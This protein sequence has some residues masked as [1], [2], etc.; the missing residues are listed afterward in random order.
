MKKK[1]LILKLAVLSWLLILGFGSFVGAVD[2]IVV[3]AWNIEDLGASNKRDST[4]KGVLQNATDIAKYVKDS[5]V[6][7]LGLE[8]ICVDKKESPGLTNSSLDE[9]V[10]IL[11]ADSGANWK[12][13]LFMA[14]GRKAR[15]QLTGVMWNEV[16][17]KPIGEPFRLPM[18]VPKHQVG[19]PIYWWRWATAMKFST[20]EAKTDFCIIPVHMK[21]N[22][23]KK[24]ESE[25]EAVKRS[26]EQRAEEAK[27]L[28]EAL[29]ETQ[30]KF[31]CED[32]II[33][34]D[35]NALS[36][37]E[38]AVKIFT[39]AGFRDLN[40]QDLVTYISKRYPTSPLDRAF[41]PKNRPSFSD[42]KMEVFKP[43]DM[44]REEFRKRLSDHYMIIFT[45]RVMDHD[46]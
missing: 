31:A 29:G 6:S 5:G 32:I 35:V 33:I 9:T 21:S 19:E 15:Q 10:K 14:K 27:L 17:L 34:G 22:R 8:E 42:S 13:R 2:Q 40:Q 3:G 23:P 36:S 20:G 28:V 39:E 7:L 16:I 4:G 43:T 26:I 41:V 24:G 11:N 38:K 18:Q 37:S 44:S 1:G 30:K 46:H 25:E 45:L 12:Y